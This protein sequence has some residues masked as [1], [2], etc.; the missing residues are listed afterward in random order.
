MHQNAIVLDCSNNSTTHKR[1]GTWNR[2]PT[3]QR[4]VQLLEWL[5][6]VDGDI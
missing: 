1:H 3:L 5:L 6:D 2:N 4:N